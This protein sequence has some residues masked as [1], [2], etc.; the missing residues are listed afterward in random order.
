MRSRPFVNPIV[1]ITLAFG[2]GAA[3]CTRA[4]QEGVPAALRVDSAL[5]VATFDSAWTRIGA[6][7]YDTTFRGMDWAGARDRLRPLAAKAREMG[8]VRSAV[9]SLFVMLG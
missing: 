5:A 7:Y 4:P 3:G 9:E 1:G 8:E 6:T 2:A